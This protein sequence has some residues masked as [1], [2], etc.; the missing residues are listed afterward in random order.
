[1]LANVSESTA[2]FAKDWKVPQNISV[3]F[4]T[5]RCLRTYLCTGIRLMGLTRLTRLVR[6]Q[7]QGTR[8]SPR[9]SLCGNAYTLTCIQILLP[10]SA[11]AIPRGISENAGTQKHM[12]CVFSRTYTTSHLEST[13][14]E[15]K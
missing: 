13:R 10:V 3:N 4:K 2:N 5:R 8:R 6:L 14:T 1:M 12:S 15:A 7:C 9:R 11:T